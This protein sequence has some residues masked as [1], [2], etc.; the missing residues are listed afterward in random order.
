MT[1]P[2]QRFEGSF[3]T[4]QGARFAIVA[5]RFNELVVE[6]L[7]AG[8]LDGLRR[9]GVADANISIT[10]TP[11][12]FELPLVCQRL[13]GSG[14]VDAV[15]ALGCV[16]RGATPHFEYV[17]GAAATGCGE[18]ALRSGIPVVFGVLTTETM[19]QALDRAGGKSGNKGL[20]AA[21]S[22]IELFNLGK[23]LADQGL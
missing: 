12:A 20:D 1:D 6:R 14:K 21:L 18:V 17:A 11:G 5:A 22:A 8:A 15:I 13:A 2:I 3:T 4:P 19:E 23:R 7:I 9:H 10:R 16:V